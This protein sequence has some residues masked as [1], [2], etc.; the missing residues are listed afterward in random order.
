MVGSGEVRLSQGTSQ[1]LGCLANAFGET[2]RKGS[3][4]RAQHSPRFAPVMNTFVVALPAA[5][6]PSLGLHSE[7]AEFA[8]DGDCS[9]VSEAGFGAA[10]CTLAE[11]GSYSCFRVVQ[12][13]LGQRLRE[14]LWGFGPETISGEKQTDDLGSKPNTQITSPFRYTIP[15]HNLNELPT[16]RVD[17]GWQYFRYCN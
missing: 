9:R 5:M 4:L 7:T 17:S 14:V 2:R 8:R 15:C 12:A 6:T 16:F 10:R 13:D 3:E 11:H 1:S